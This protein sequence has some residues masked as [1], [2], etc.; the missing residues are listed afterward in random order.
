MESRRGSKRVEQRGRFTIT[1]I[2]P[3]SP[4]SPPASVFDR[5]AGDLS[6]EGAA[7]PEM[8]EDKSPLR[9][10]ELESAPAAT[11]DAAE[12][13]PADAQPSPAREEAAPLSRG[14][15]NDVPV[16]HGMIPESPALVP[17]VG[18]PVLR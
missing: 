10:E 9:P 5:E 13:P 17:Q 2:I 4:L 7:E 8:S 14:S 1:E 3:G 16:T 6:P 15:N 18:W 11:V 12:A